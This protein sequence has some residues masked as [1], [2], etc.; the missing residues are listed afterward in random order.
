[1]MIVE[2]RMQCYEI[3]L[4]TSIGVR[5]GRMTAKWSG[6]RIGGQIDI[7]NHREAFE[8]SADEEGRCRIRGRLVSMT[9][10]LPYEAEGRMSDREV[11]LKVLTDKD[12]YVLTG[13]PLKKE[14]EL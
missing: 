3:A 8:G 1:M 6:N 13:V 2:E 9:K 11:H 12:Q 10:V 14:G 4:N 5:Y 7:L